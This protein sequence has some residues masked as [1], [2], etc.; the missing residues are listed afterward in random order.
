MDDPEKKNAEV[1]SPAGEATGGDTRLT[2]EMEPESIMEID[3]TVKTFTG[4]DTR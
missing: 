2:E 4:G 1:L 3:V